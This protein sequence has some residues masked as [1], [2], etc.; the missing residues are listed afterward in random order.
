MLRN[1]Q[2]FSKLD[3][4]T[5]LSKATDSEFDLIMKLLKFDPGK[6]LT[7]REAIKHSYFDE[8]RDMVDGLRAVP[9]KITDCSLNK[10]MKIEDYYS[11][12]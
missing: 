6:R 3:A 12:V 11:L 9:T 2:T 1:F 10:E 7:V 8:V 5:L 4:K